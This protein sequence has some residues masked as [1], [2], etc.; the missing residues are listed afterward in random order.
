EQSET[1]EVPEVEEIVDTRYSNYD[2]APEKVQENSKGYEDE[3]KDEPQ[4][5]PTSHLP[6]G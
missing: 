1:I 5:L 6:L 4:A 2:D 3:S